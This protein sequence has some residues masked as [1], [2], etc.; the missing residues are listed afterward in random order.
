VERIALLIQDK[1]WLVVIVMVALPALIWIGALRAR[2]RR[3][4]R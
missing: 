3:R 4:R 1:P 2:R